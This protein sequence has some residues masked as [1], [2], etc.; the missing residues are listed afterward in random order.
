MNLLPEQYKRDLRFEAWRRFLIFFG[1]YA[2]VAGIIAIMLLMPSYFF[3]NFQIDTLER[4][5]ESLQSG[6]N[7]RKTQEGQQQAREINRAL[8][9]LVSF[10]NTSSKISLP[11]EEF[12]GRVIPGITLTTFTYGDRP[13]GTVGVQMIGRAST[14]DTYLTFIDT[15]QNSPYTAEKITPSVSELLKENDI[16]FTL[17]FAA[18]K[19]VK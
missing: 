9:L 17:T 15:L 2:S 7:F 18:R 3:L 10:E 14:R 13:D 16:P 6:E 8:G 1:M 4:Q 5:Y 12:L 11:V 19:T